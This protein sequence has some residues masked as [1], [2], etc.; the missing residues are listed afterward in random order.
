MPD[1]DLVLDGDALADE[2]VARHFAAPADGGIFLHFDEG[3]DLRPVA[4]RTAVE[5]D[6]AGELHVAPEPHVVRDCLVLI[7]KVTLSRRQRAPFPEITAAGVA[8]RILRSLRSEQVF[9]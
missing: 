9:A 1:E 2:R 6:E 3:A 8:N 7:H 4:D 5:V